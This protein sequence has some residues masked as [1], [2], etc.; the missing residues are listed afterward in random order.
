[1]NPNL[2]NM[3][4][5]LKRL[6]KKIAAGARFVQT[7]PVYSPKILDELLSRTESMGV[8]V[9]VGVLPLVSERNAEFLHNEVPGITLPDD[10]RS[11]MRG[12]RGEE[13][14][15]EGMAIARELTEA[16]RGRVGGWYIMPPFGKVRIALDLMASIRPG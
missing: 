9:L 4:G 2:A 11:R 15:A 12:K 7:Q 13:G 14:V 8:P 3:S 5:Q 10:V 16:G 6:E 1:L